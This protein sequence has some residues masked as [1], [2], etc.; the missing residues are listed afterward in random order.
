[1][2]PALP[3]PFD[4]EQRDV[5]GFTPFSGMNFGLSGPLVTPYT[6]HPIGYPTPDTG[7]DGMLIDETFQNQQDILINFE[8]P[9]D[10]LLIELVRLFFEHLYQKFPCFHKQ[11]F[12]RNVENGQLQKEAPL[13]LYAM[14]CITSRHH[15]DIAVRKRQ[16]DWYDQAKLSYD[17]TRRFPEQ[18]LRT[19]QAVII[20]IY[21]AFTVGDFSSS[22]LSLGKSWRQA[23][24]LGM[25]RMDADHVAPKPRHDSAQ[26]PEEVLG[27]EMSRGRTSVE[28]EE[29]RRTLWILF[30]MDR[31]HAWPTGWPNAILDI[32]FKVDLPIADTLFQAMDPDL[33]TS[34]Y[35]NTPFTRNLNRL[36]NSLSHAKEP[37]NFFHYISVAHVLLGRISELIHSLHDNPGTQ[38][39]AEECR[40]LD[41]YIVKFR[42]SLPRQATSV[43]EAPPEERGNVVWLNVTLNIL[44][45]LLH[46]RCGEDALELSLVVAAARNTAQIVK[47]AARFS[48]DLVLSA[49]FGASLYIAAAILVI[50]SR[51]T[52]D[53][54]S[55][56][57]D[58]DIL[59]LVFERMSEIYVFSGLKFKLA[60]E[61]DQTRSLEEIRNLNERGFRGLL[62]DCTKWGF[63]K[64]EVVRRGLFID[65][66]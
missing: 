8:L 19:M 18:A 44:V 34:P 59:G 38:E 49:H 62:A 21:H 32:Q 45:M 50:Q 1:M 23:V 16:S 37:V 15:P 58:I 25:N 14:C 40:E 4:L 5:Q 42:L 36:I 46:Y 66:T 28:R 24:A 57:E 9:D 61:H 31:S 65:I 26:H 2:Q 56:K 60:L 22:W 54:E 13:V 11:S 3:F 6:D 35:T 33:E 55:F 30:M 12:L 41:S 7:A 27:L 10:E 53:E 52:G 43:M 47:D 64:D 17:L 39:Y 20:L 63:V 29:Y 48:I 51:L